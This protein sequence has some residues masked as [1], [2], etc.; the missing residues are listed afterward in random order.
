MSGAKKTDKRLWWLLAVAALVSL[1]WLGVTIGLVGA[2]LDD[3]GRATIWR[4]LGEQ[5]V[6]LDRKSVV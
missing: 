4:L 5:S 3:D 6:L 2:T 1:V